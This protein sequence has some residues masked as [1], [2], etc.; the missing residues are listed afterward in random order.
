MDFYAAEVRL[1]VELDGDSHYADAAAREHDSVRDHYLHSLGIETLR[2]SNNDVMRNR[3]GVLALI[4][5]VIARQPPPQPS[6]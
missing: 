2:F 5:T 1:A 6:P 4:Q 3:A